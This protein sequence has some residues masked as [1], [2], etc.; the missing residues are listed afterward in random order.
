MIKAGLNG[1]FQANSE[2]KEMFNEMKSYLMGNQTS[3]I[4]CIDLLK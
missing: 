2:V 4:K 3:K 1:V